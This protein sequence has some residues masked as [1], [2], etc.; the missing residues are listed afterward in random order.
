MYFF[1]KILYI[2]EPLTQL[3][4]P[5]IPGERCSLAVSVGGAHPEAHQAGPLSTGVGGACHF[6]LHV[7]VNLSLLPKF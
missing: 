2:V 1:L 4:I 3:T 5:K 6:N 7:L